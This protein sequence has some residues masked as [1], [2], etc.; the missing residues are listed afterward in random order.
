MKKFLLVLFMV[1]TCNVANSKDTL[2]L[3]DMQ[4]QLK[5]M[6]FENQSLKERVTDLDN[7]NTKFLTVTYSTIGFCFL[8]I[9]GSTLWNTY[10]STRL[11]KKRWENWANE[12]TLKTYKNLSD[13]ID[14][15]IDRKF[16]SKFSEI[17]NKLKSIEQNSI[18]AKILILKKTNKLLSKKETTDD[19]EASIEYLKLANELYKI[20]EY[21]DFDLTQSLQNI[22]ELLTN[23]K[24]W[25][26]SQIDQISKILPKID[27]KYVRYVNDIKTILKI[28]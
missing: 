22:K 5:Q 25:I 21:C 16:N 24:D 13:D 11:D 14:K 27:I 23:D 1:V 18:E 6:Q 17:S 10:S 9:L 2:T 19:F 20:T 15:K 8:I 4:S 3:N 28:N 7:V 12:F 26:D